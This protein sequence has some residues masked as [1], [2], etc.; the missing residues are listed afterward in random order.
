[1][2]ILRSR[3]RL[4]VELHREDRPILEAQ[5]FERPVEQRGLGLL[6]AR[7]QG[8]P[9][10]GEAVVMRGDLDAAGCE[11][12]NRMVAAAVTQM[13]LDGASAEGEGEQL[14]PKADAEDRQP[15]GKQLADYGDGEDAGRRRIARTIGE[16]YSIGPQC[17]DRRGRSACR[18]DGDAAA[19]TSQAAQDV[20]LGTVVHAHD[21]AVRELDLAVAAL[22]GPRGLDP[23]VGLDARNL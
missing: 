12:L 11:I 7:R 18:D 5:T 13:H 19:E 16:K 22:N 9:R 17:E 6:Q 23:L 8:L 20:T 15:R 3:A 4:R 21:M 14:V 1:M 10:H 2:T